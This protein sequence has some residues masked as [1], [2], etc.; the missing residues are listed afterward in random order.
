MAL[1]MLA[2]S[3]LRGMRGMG[4]LAEAHTAG[5]AAA[6]VAPSSGSTMN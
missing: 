3:D 1:A 2:F 5:L 6:R 4:R